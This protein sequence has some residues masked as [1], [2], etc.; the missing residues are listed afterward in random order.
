M[1]PERRYVPYEEK[2]KRPKGFGS[3]C[4]SEIPLGVVQE[5]LENA[6]EVPEEGK[7]LWNA[8]GRW[9]FRANPTRSE[10]G[11]WHGFPMIG[12]EVP[13]R[14]LSS[15]FE[16]GMINRQELRRLRKQRSLPEVWP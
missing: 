12:G 9:C 16:A 11:V 1:A 13:D 5:L 6:I 15:L 2:H 3:L 8:R 14:V 4:P 10:A 7:S